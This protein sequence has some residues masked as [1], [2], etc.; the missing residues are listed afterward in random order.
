[1]LE[2]IL[3]VL[4][5]YFGLKIIFRFFGPA[6]MRWTMKKI[7]KKMER[8]FRQQYG[9]FSGGQTPEGE[10]PVHE[11]PHFRKETVRS[12]H[13][14]AKQDEEYIDYEEID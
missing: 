10:S 12:K 8:K 6:I 7:G 5:V 1:M 9:G 2:F 4:L 3:I 14:S 11:K 13:K